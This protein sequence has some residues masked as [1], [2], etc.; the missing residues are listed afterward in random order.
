LGKLAL[1][2]GDPELGKSLLTLDLCARL[3]TGRPWPDETPLPGP[4]SAVVVN[5]EDREDD[6]LCPR[7]RALGADLERVFFLPRDEGGEID[8]GLPARTAALD[9]VLTA[10]GARLVVIDPITV[11]LAAGVN[12]HSDGGVRR[13]LAPLA[14][15]ARQH[16]C[17]VLMVRHLTKNGGHRALYR[18]LG[19]IGLVGS[20]RSAWLIAADPRRKGRRVL[21]QEKNNLGAPQP[22]LG[23]EVVDGAGGLPAVSWLGTADWTADA[24]LAAAAARPDQPGPIDF[25]REFLAEVLKDGPRTARE[26]WVQ[27]EPLGHSKATLGRAREGLKVRTRRVFRDGRPT[28]YW[29]LPHQQLPPDAASADDNAIDEALRLLAEQYPPSTPLD[30]L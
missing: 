21:A 16:G 20:C 1:L 6:T 30:E 13:A 22:S 14:A 15:L 11:F 8:F 17:A 3:S 29:M 26:I 18:G 25:A 9:R 28:S 7:L 4:L 10:T 2:D 24:L 23:F 27:A 5:A 19:S 12:T